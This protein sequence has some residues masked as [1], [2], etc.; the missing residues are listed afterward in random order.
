MFL[1][2][3]APGREYGREVG[4]RSNMQCNLPRR[5][6]DS[7]VEVPNAR[8]ASDSLPADFH[9]FG[10]RFKNPDLRDGQELREGPYP[11]TAVGPDVDYK[12]WRDLK[13]I[14]KIENRDL[15][16]AASVLGEHA[17]TQG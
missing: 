1:Q 6:A 5:V 7:Y 8:S 9:G 17:L 13:L 14:G 4:R 12:R 3:F 15:W 11:F 2:E 10:L 16:M